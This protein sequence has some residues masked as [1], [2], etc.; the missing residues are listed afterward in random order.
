MAEEKS[1]LKESKLKMTKSST[2]LTTEIKENKEPPSGAKILTKTI[3]TSTEQIENG[4]L[5]SKNYDISYE[6]KGEKRWTYYSKKWFSKT[7]PLEVKVTDKSLA[8]EFDDS[9]E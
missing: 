8:E 6:V 2:T 1:K 3:S 4:W 5:I 9:D 7:D